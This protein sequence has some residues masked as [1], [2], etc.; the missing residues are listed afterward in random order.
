MKIQLYGK[1]ILWHMIRITFFYMVALLLGGGLLYADPADAQSLKQRVDLVVENKPIAQV[2]RQIEEQTAIRFIYTNNLL[3]GV[4]NVT[5]DVQRQTASDV[6]K[7][8]LS[9]LAIQ[10]EEKDRG[11]VVLTKRAETQAVLASLASLS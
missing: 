5:L 4:E 11:Y 8:L 9:P 7:T 10:Y 3:D 6:L 2:L 1:A